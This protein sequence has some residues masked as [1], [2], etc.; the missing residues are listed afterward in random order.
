MAT[1][2]E[3]Y[4]MSFDDGLKDA[5]EEFWHKN[6]LPSRNSA[7]N[8][9]L[10]IALRKKETLTTDEMRV[11]EEFRKAPPIARHMTRNLLATANS[12]ANTHYSYRMPS[13]AL[14]GRRAE[15]ARFE[16]DGII[17]KEYGDFSDY[18]FEDAISKIGEAADR[19]ITNESQ[20]S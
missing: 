15:I 11:I 10:R 4:T 13:S 5:V 14:G 20:N 9:L 12:Y 3:R 1:E 18:E 17:Y 8:E 7:I 16:K 19:I 6:A 2:K